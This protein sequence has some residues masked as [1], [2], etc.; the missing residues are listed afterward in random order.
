MSPLRPEIIR[1]LEDTDVA[2]PPRPSWV[3]EAIGLGFAMGFVTTF[4]AAALVWAFL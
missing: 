2:I 4:W 3:A 1:P